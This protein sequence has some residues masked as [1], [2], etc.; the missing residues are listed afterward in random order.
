MKKSVSIFLVLFVALS[1]LSCSN[2]RVIEDTIELTEEEEIVTEET[3]IEEVVIDEE[4]ILI[5][6]GEEELVV[7]NK[8]QSITMFTK[9]IVLKV[10]GKAEYVGNVHGSVGTE[11]KCWSKDVSILK[12]INK[13]FKYDSPLIPGQTGGDSAK[14]TYTFK[15]MREGTTKVTIQ[16]WFRGQLEHEQIVTIIVI[17]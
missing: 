4:E 17:K 9:K 15:A 14:E 7:S 11:K 10:G 5:E 6:E 3:V 12:L 13:K 1:H 16:N 8:K 2:V